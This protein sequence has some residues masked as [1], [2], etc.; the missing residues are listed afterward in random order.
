MKPFGAGFSRYAFAFLKA[1]RG[2]LRGLV[3]ALPVKLT[4]QELMGPMKIS[5]LLPNDYK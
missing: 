1:A 3:S 5:K 4:K 2:S